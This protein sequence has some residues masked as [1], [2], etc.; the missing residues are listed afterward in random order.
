MAVTCQVPQEENAETEFSVQGG[1]LE[2]ILGSTAM[3]GG[4]KNPNW[5]KGDVD[6]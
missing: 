1:Y 3:E 5:A 2:V 4:E 6:Y